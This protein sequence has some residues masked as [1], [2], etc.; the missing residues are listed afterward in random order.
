MPTDDFRA[1]YQ[2]ELRVAYGTTRGAEVL[3]ASAAVPPAS[4]SIPRGAVPALL[5]RRQLGRRWLWPR[6]FPEEARIGRI[7]SQL[8]SL[9]NLDTAT[10][11]ELQRLK[12]SAR[13][14][15]AR[16]KG[17]SG[18]RPKSV[19]PVKAGTGKPSKTRVKTTVKTKGDSKP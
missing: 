1:L 18:K 8:K 3:A 6:A 11:R 14:S 4:N 13:I 5:A 10:D 7:E 15:A 16:A 9:E 19:V 2:Q 17:R 12:R